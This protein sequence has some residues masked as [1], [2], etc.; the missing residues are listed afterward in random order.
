M[1]DP[2]RA[3][4]LALLV[5]ALVGLGAASALADGDPTTTVPEPAPTTTTTSVPAT[6][7]PPPAPSLLPARVSIGGVVVGGLDPAA[8]EAIVLEHFT[9]PLRLVVRGRVYKASPA[10]LGVTVYAKGAVLRALASDPG[11]SV[12]PVVTV[13][14]EDVR[15]YVDRLAEWFDRKPVAERFQLLHGAP[16]ITPARNG[17]VLDRG[18]AVEAIVG[19]LRDGTRGSIVLASVV[20]QPA[21]PPQSLSRIIVI[22]RAAN[23]LDLYRGMELWRQF[24]VAT[25][26]AAYPT[27]L[28]AFSIVVKW[29]N[30]WWYP[31]ASPWAA[32][33]S[34][35]P[36]GP[37]NPLGTRWMGLSAPGV[38]IH[39][40]PHDD[41]IG[42]SLSHGC[43]RMH[44]PQA[45]WLFNQV[46]IGTPV[47]IVAT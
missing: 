14:G 25:G 13:R 44:I 7:V 5:A 11:S 1:L 37:G 36:P 4:L 41:S 46:Q 21:A 28:G 18:A 24:R 33:E 9:K 2:R 26:Q 16:K 20:T 15:A 39:G 29:V 45:E 32:G 22:H 47:Y 3:A 19:A 34:P 30:P 6:Q 10:D 40:T 35:V 31:P 12:T 17:L 38:G 8:A 43:I 42:Y 23:T 27:P